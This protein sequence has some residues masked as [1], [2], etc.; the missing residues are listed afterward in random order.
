MI[1]DAW[2]ADEAFLTGTGAE[3]VPIASVDGARARTAP[4]CAARPPPR[5]RSSFAQRRLARGRRAPSTAPCDR[6]ARRRRRTP[7]RSAPMLLGVDVGGTFTDAVLASPDGELHTA[8]A[9]TTPARRVGR[10]ARARSSSRSRRPAAAASAV[11]AFAHGTT[12]TTN[13]LLEGRAAPHGAARDRGLHRSRRARPPGARRA[14]PA[15][16]RASARRWCRASCASRSTSAAARTARCARRAGCDALAGRVAARAAS[17]RSPS[18]C[19]TPRRTRA[20]SSP[21]AT[22]CARGCPDVHV[23]LSHEV[24]AAPR[25]YERG[26]TTEI[27][28]ALS[29]LLRAHLASLGGALRASAACRSPAV[30]QSSGGLDER[31]RGGRARRVHGAL[32]PGR[33]RPGRAPA[34][35]RGRTPRRALLRH[36]RH[37]VRRLRDRRGRRARDRSAHD[38]R[39]PARAAEPRHR[40][41]RRRRRLD[42]LARRAAARCA[43]ARARPA[44]RPA[45]PPTAA[46]ARE[47]T[48]TDAHVVLGHLPAAERR[49][50]AAC[51]L[52]RDAGAG[53]GRARSRASSAS[54]RCARRRASST[55]PTPR[56]SARC[57]R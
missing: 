51:A 18:C 15:L 28:A 33:R 49:S 31:R 37:L 56:C 21:S 2:T 9:P 4:R 38:R 23:S 41:R 54:S 13:A 22:R 19:C 20:T 47:P 52:D 8:K 7:L 43:S 10:R 6:R 55:S 25:E 27:D 1:A 26:A 34:R 17:R 44:R 57:A 53:G 16:R 48:V 50:P 45:R 39:A 12:V 29:P 30:M 40:D 36:G 24:S 11:E 46:A 14:L 35:R 3:V 42:R 5:A 32:G